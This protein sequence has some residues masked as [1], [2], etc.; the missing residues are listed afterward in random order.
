[1]AVVKIT[2]EYDTEKQ[3][4][5]GLNADPEYFKSKQSVVAVLEEAVGVCKFDLN[6]LRMQMVQQAA[7]QQAQASAIAAQVQNKRLLL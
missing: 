1:M 5:T 2:V 6:L 3:V 7:M 4:V